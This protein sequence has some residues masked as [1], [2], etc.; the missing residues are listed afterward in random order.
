MPRSSKRVAVAED[1]LPM[2][3]VIALALRGDG[4]DVYEAANGG[5]L[6][7][8]ILNRSSD[9]QFDLIISDVRMPVATG[10]EVVVA[11]RQMDCTL[12]VILMTA[13]G[14][15]SL[16]DASAR[17]GV[18]VLHKPFDLDDLRLAARLLT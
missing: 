8:L 15:D 9:G 4:F 18:R 1:D 10:V 11:L 12:P 13:F 17:L 16:E 5:E 6:L 14:D 2:R 7:D 3:R